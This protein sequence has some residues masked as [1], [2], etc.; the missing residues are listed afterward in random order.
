MNYLK[1]KY[2]NQSSTFMNY[3]IVEK[4]ILKIESIVK[5]TLNFIH[6]QLIVTLNFSYKHNVCGNEKE[7][8]NPCL[9]TYLIRLNY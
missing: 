7:K 4:K 6:H 8:S 3:E 2:T 5:S 1:S 9:H